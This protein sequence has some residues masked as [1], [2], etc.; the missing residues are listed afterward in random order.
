MPYDANFITG[1]TIP[2]PTPND[3]VLQSTFNGDYILHSRHSLLFNQDRGFALVSANNVA[4][5]ARAMVRETLLDGRVGAGDV[6]DELNDTVIS[7]AT[8]PGTAAI[9]NARD[10]VL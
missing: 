4:S 10:I 7:R 5:R 2:L 6:L 3:R 1:H 8:R 9:T